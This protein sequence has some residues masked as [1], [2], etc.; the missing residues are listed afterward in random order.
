MGNTEKYGDL[1]NWSKVD[2]SRLII[3]HMFKL[4]RY[5]ACGDIRVKRQMRNRKLVLIYRA[6]IALNKMATI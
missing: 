2:L 6:E 3:K 5:P 4:D 1:K